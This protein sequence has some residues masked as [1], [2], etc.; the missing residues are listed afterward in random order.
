MSVFF[1]KNNCMVDS[2]IIIH[3]VIIKSNIK[4]TMLSEDNGT[5]GIF[6]IIL[7]VVYFI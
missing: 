6:L 5:I 4:A 3:K 2:Y 7:F 1:Y